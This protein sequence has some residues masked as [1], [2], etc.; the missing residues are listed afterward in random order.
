MKVTELQDQKNNI[1]VDLSV[2]ISKYD[3]N[4]FLI[5]SPEYFWTQRNVKAMFKI[6]IVF[7]MN[8]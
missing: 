3:N 1:R 2:N 8:L 5:Q 4:L 7:F 6:N